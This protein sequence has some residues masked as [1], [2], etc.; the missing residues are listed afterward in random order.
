MLVKKVVKLVKQ[1]VKMVKQ[2]VKM[3]KQVVKTDLQQ[4]DGVGVGVREPRRQ[5]HGC[6]WSNWSN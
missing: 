5:R 3:A 6:K 4:V 2:V 1:V